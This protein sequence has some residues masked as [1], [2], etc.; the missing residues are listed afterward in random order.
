MF[1]ITFF[2]P[3]QLPRVHHVLP[4][5]VTAWR[6]GNDWREV[7]VGYPDGKYRVLL[8]ES[9]ATTDIIAQASAHQLPDTEL[10]GARDQC[11]QGQ[12]PHDMRAEMAVHHRAECKS[13]G[14]Y[15][16]NAPQLK[17]KAS[18]QPHDRSVYLRQ[19]L[20]QCPRCKERRNEQRKH[21]PQDNQ[22]LMSERACGLHLHQWEHRRNHHRRH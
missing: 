3:P 21:T 1:R 2:F 11:G 12:Q 8:A 9:L 14:Y 5:D 6:H 15:Q 7:G 16:R 13:D 20:P 17:R 18:A 4:D 10:P 19:K 22:E